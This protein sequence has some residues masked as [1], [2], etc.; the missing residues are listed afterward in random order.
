MK[1]SDFDYD[2]P[3]RFIAQTPANPRDHSRLLIYDRATGKT[4]IKHF[5]DIVDYLQSGDVV[6]INTTRVMQ[7][8]LHGTKDNS[9]TKFE[10]LLLKTPASLR[11]A[12]PLLKGDLRNYKYEVLVKPMKRLKPGDKVIFAGGVVGELLS[13]DEVAGTA[14]MRFNKCPE[15]AGKAPLPPYITVSDNDPERYQTVYAG[16]AGSAAAPTAGLHWTPELM[17]KARDKGVIFCEILLHVGIGTFRPVKCEDIR[18]HEMHSE[19]YEIPPASAKIIA[20]AKAQ[21]RRVIAVGTTTVRTLESVYIKHG[22]IVA[23]CGETNIFI[24]PPYDFR[25]V[26]A[27]ITNFHLPK[28]SL[29]M[30]VTAFLGGGK[31][32]EVLELYETAKQNDF[33]FF[34]FGDA[35]F[36]C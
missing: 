6:V 21:G 15:V 35:M 11:E 33:R 5:Y 16:M 32:I 8:R 18:D 30:L 2:L 4:D 25:V 17:Q 3:E 24:Y 28:S 13:K 34:S 10:V 1:L 29:L 31:H 22:K 9:A 20:D 12:P 23:D 27:M 7:A 36:L 14:V 19:Y 26:D